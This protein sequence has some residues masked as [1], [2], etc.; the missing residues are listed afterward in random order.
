MYDFSALEDYFQ[1]IN[2]PKK[3]WIDMSE[4]ELFDI[5][6]FHKYSGYDVAKA[7]AVLLKERNE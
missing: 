1:R 7:V 3:E 2:K 5:L 6:R 4:D